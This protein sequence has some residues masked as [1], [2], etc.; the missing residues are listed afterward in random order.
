MRAEGASRL[1]TRGAVAGLAFVAVIALVLAGAKPSRAGDQTLYDEMGGKDGLTK[2][3]N[4]AMDAYVGDPRISDQFDNINFD[5]LKGRLILHFCQLTGGP[6]K[7]PG[8]DMYAA[9]KGLHIDS[10]SFNAVVEDLEGAMDK[11]GIPFRTQNR[12]LALLAPMK[13]KIVTQ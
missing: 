6:C 9:H 1:T 3:V 12:L 11:A 8:R 10:A 13:K 5:W 7:Y 2:I 4:Y